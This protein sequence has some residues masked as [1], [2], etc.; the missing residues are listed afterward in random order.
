MR[1]PRQGPWESP[2]RLPESPQGSPQDS[3]DA[4]DVWAPRP[5]PCGSCTMLVDLPDVLQ[6]L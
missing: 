5:A 4:H 1:P 2:V 6:Q 3:R